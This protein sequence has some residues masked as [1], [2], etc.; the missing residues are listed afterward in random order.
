MKHRIFPAF[1]LLFY[2][3]SFYF[4]LLLFTSFSGLSRTL[5]SLF[6]LV[7]IRF[8]I[9]GHA[10]SNYRHERHP[11][12]STRKSQEINSQKFP[13]QLPSCP[14]GNELNYRV[15]Y[16]KIGRVM[17]FGSRFGAPALSSVARRLSRVRH[18]RSPH[19]VKRAILSKIR[20]Y[21]IKSSMIS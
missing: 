14:S 10:G 20:S 11:A 13:N 15:V 3:F 9:A 12:A 1:F 7:H 8:F 18:P 16:K 4:F 6:H 5:L 21:L 2:L 17:N 19:L